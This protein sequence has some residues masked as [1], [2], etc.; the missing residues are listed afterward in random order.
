ML[1][2]TRK[3][4]TGRFMILMLATVTLVTLGGCGLKITENFAGRNPDQVWTALVAVAETPDYDNPEFGR[5]TVME[6]DVW[7]NGDKR[8]IEI[9]REIRRSFYGPGD[10]Q[11]RREDQTWEIQIT[12][13]DDEEDGLHAVFKVRNWSIPA[14]VWNEADRYFADVRE[15]LGGM[16]VEAPMSAPESAP[17]TAPDEAD[18]ETPAAPPT[19]EPDD[20]GGAEEPPI[21]IDDLTGDG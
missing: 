13:A 16:P 21:D 17:E 7:A 18:A 4:T 14:Y 12:L 9:Y 19:T 5:W 1:G 2:T 15:I 8:R 10:P 6:N 3:H 11:G 20:A